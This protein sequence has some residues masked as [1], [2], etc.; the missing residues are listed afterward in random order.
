LLALQGENEQALADYT[1]AINYSARFA[2]AYYSR[3]RIHGL[4]GDYR[5]ALADL[6]K[7][8][9]LSPRASNRDQVEAIIQDLR[10][11]Y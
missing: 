8:L 1:Q 11:K 3:G 7:Y 9:E 6:E 10:S 4:A 5:Q 2:P